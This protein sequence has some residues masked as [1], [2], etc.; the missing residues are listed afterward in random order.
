ML[1]RPQHF[2][3]LRAREKQR[4]YLKIHSLPF[5]SLRRSFT[6]KIPISSHCSFVACV[7]NKLCIESENEFSLLQHSYMN[8][9]CFFEYIPQ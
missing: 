4:E 5:Y 6:R 1:Y 3:L 7:V 2:Q 8:M 9:K